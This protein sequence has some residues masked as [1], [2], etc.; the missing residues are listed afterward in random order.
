[1]QQLVGVLSLIPQYLIVNLRVFLCIDG[2][3][4]R[5]AAYLDGVDLQDCCFVF[6]SSTVYHCASYGA[7]VKHAQN[8]PPSHQ[9]PEPVQ[10]KRQRMIPGAVILSPVLTA[11][12][13]PRC[14]R[15]LASSLAL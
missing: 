7:R 9:K 2:S 1:M 4:W 3:L 6:I 11:V 12:L 5:I 14:V 8:F 13:G 15:W 10:T